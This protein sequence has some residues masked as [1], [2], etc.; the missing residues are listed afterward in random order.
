MTTPVKNALRHSA[1][2]DVRR[3]RQEVRLR[4]RRQERRSLAP[5][6]RR[7]RAAARASSST[8]GLDEKDKVLLDG[9]RKVRDGAADRKSDFKRAAPTCSRHFAGWFATA[10]SRTATMFES[11]CVAPCWRSSLSLDAASSWACLRMRIAPGLAVPRDL[12]ASRHGLARLPG[13][14]RRRLGAVL[15]H[16][17]GARD[18]R[19]SGHEL[20]DPPTRRAPVRRPFRSSSSSD[21]DPNQAVVNV[22][23]RVD[24]VLNRLPPLVQLEGVIVNRVQPSMLMYVN[25]YSYGEDGRSEVSLQLRQRQSSRP[26]S[27]ASRASRRLASSVLRQYAMR[28]WLN[29]G[30]DAGLQRLDRRRD[31]G[32]RRAER[33]RPPW[34][35][36]PGVR[37]AGAGRSNT[38]SST[39]A[40]TTS[41]SSTR[42]SSSGPIADGEMLRLKDIATI[43]LG[44]EFFDIYSN[45]DGHPS[46]AIVL[47]QNLRQQRERGHRERQSQA[48]GAQEDLV[49][50]GDGLRDQLRRLELPR[51]LD[52]EGRFTRSA[53]PSSS[54]RSS[55]SSSWAIGARRSFRCWPF[56]CRSSARSC[57]CRCSGSPST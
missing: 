12:A 15:A 5:H 49:P 44:S 47:K 8:S 28:V 43:E 52:R 9:L 53:R 32:D 19:R 23:N 3:P 36:R 7:R 37:Q 26:S 13:S 2:G 51:R 10:R 6:H 1:E 18:Q 11:S 27:V 57:S 17:A 16:H 4:G 33:H 25:L 29:P 48:G 56:P 30:Q 41:P 35:A 40:A 14:E 45:L 39:R 55:C 34:T 31:E 22:K 46:A 42:T 20:H 50:R 38:S 24:Q 54:W 21:A